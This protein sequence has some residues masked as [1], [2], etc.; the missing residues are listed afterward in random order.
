MQTSKVQ[1]R[2]ARPL[3]WYAWRLARYRMGLYVL[4]GLCISIAFYLMAL[5]PGLILQ[6]FFTQLSGAAQ[7]G[8]N[9]WSLLAL[10]VAAG[11]GRTLLLFMAV[12]VENTLGKVM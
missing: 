3:L 10:F 12:T 6:Q 7:A 8:L 9:V 1:K 2:L 11:V 5:L 4:N